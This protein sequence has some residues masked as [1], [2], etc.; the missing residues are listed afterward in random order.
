MDVQYHGEIYGTIEREKIT[1]KAWN[2]RSKN[3]LVEFLQS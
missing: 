2:N 3:V 1:M